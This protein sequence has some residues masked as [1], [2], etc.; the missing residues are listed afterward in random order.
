MHVLK[1]GIDADKICSTFSRFLYSWCVSGKPE[2]GEKIGAQL[3]FGNY[4]LVL[5]KHRKVSCIK[6]IIYFKKA[7]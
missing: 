5:P 1:Q 7:K 3:A 6:W 2:M 4:S